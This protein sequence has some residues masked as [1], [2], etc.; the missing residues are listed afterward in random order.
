ML[1]CEDDDD[2]TVRVGLA[3]GTFKL[4]VK[5]E[6]TKERAM[7]PC[8][9]KASEEARRANKLPAAILIIQKRGPREVLIPMVCVRH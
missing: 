4:L 8:V 2:D 1:S 6:L 9:I 5:D 3:P 7:G